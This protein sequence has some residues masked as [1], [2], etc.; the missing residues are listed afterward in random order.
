[1]IQANTELS[2]KDPNNDDEDKNNN[3]FRFSDVFLGSSQGKLYRLASILSIDKD[4]KSE[5]D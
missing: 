2:L 1:M 5:K 3:E 4:Q